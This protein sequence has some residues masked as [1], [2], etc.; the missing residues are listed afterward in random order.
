MDNY[1]DENGMFTKKYPA[2]QTAEEYFKN[3]EV[4]KEIVKKRTN[5][6]KN[7]VEKNN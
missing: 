6:I 2:P 3:I 4:Q 7:F 5:R 1:F